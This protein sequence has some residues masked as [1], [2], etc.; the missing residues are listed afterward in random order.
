MLHDPTK[1]YP[2]IAWMILSD[3]TQNL[4]KA[5]IQRTPTKENAA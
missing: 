1:R 2:E 5:F 4:M 3:L